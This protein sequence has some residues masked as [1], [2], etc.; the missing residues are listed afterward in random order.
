MINIETDRLIIRDH[1]EEDIESV[2]NLLSDEKAMHYLPDIKT[3]TLDESKQNLYEAI[4]ESHLESRTKYFFAI[5]ERTTDKYIGEIGYTVIID[6]SEGKVVNLGYFILPMYWGKGFVTETAKAVADYAFNS[7]NV[8][9]IETGC[10]KENVGSEWVMKKV[11]M[12]KEA[13]LVKH[14]LLHSKLHDRVE[15]RLLKEEWEKLER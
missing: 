10:V 4:K 6:S 2:H 12:I 3:N 8:I 9:K 1:I 15:Y 13:E 7:G 5:I 11:G 14:V